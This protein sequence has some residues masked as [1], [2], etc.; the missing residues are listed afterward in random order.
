MPRPRIDARPMTLAERRSRRR[1]SSARA[2]H[3]PP[4]P[5]LPTPPRLQRWAPAVAALIDLRDEIPSL[6]PQS[7]SQPG[8][9][10]TGGKLQTIRRTRS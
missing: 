7:A 6:A 2:T 4:P 8:R 1:A 3:P 5:A 9:V 10:D